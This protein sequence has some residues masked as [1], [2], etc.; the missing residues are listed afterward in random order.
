M[1]AVVVNV[2]P[3]CGVEEL[4]I[5]KP[6]GSVSVKEAAVNGSVDTFVKVMAKFE[7]P[8]GPTMVG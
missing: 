8:F 3:H 5:V 4:V 7:K 2:P 6:A 1:A